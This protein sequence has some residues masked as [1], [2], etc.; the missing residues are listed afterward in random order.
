M[1]GHPTVWIRLKRAYEKP[2]PADGCRILVERLWPR[3]LSKDA[4]KFDLWAKD[5]PE[6]FLF[7]GQPIEVPR[8]RNL[9]KIEGVQENSHRSGHSS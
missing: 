5:A 9:S 7:S 3:G 4:A 2:T 1:K 6:G 8:L